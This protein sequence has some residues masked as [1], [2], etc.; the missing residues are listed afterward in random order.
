MRHAQAVA[1][2]CN[3][4]PL[5]SSYPRQRF[6]P[7]NDI[8]SSDRT[9][10]LSDA[11]GSPDKRAIRAEVNSQTVYSHPCFQTLCTLLWAHGSHHF[12]LSICVVRLSSRDEVIVS[13]QGRD[14]YQLTALWQVERRRDAQPDAFIPHVRL[15]EHTISSNYLSLAPG[16]VLSPLKIVNPHQATSLP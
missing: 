1:R 15:A 16:W 11:L 12:L 5:W 14:A 4:E 3:V 8:P 10:F 9:T 2:S 13:R 6:R 7:H